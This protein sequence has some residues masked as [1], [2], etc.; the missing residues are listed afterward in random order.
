MC[1]GPILAAAFTASA[2]TAA[3]AAIDAAAA[4]AVVKQGEETEVFFSLI[5][6]CVVA[7]F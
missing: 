6:V 1:G 5:G 2:A 4:T 3:A 7:L